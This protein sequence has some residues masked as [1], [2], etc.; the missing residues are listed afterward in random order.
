MICFSVPMTLRSKRGSPCCL[1]TTGSYQKQGGSWG[2]LFLRLGCSLLF[3]ASQPLPHMSQTLVIQTKSWAAGSVVTSRTYWALEV[4]R[5]HSKENVAIFAPQIQLKWCPQVLE[6]LSEYRLQTQHQV[7]KTD[8]H[9]GMVP[10]W[11]A[12]FK[13]LLLP[14]MMVHAVNPSIWE[15]ESRGSVSSKPAWPTEKVQISQNQQRVTVSEH[16]NSQI[17]YLNSSLPSAEK[18]MA[19]SSET[20]QATLSSEASRSHDWISKHNISYF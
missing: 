3:L 10:I 16:R 5:K 19:V 2:L 7:I 11:H 8:L 4:R 18:V 17:S 12:S 14:G 15:T 9:L 1:N 6:T 13:L 20:A